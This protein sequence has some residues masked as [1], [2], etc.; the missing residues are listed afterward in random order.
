MLEA[1]A[2]SDPQGD[3][4]RTFARLAAQAPDVKQAEAKLEAANRSPSTFDKRLARPLKL[5]GLKL[6]S[7][8]QSTAAAIQ[9]LYD[10]AAPTAPPKSALS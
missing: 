5:A 1:F 4:D 10:G 3:I 2:K 9:H 7:G 6:G 8:H